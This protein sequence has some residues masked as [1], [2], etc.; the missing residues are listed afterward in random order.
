V[1]FLMSMGVC[2]RG[3][4]VYTPRKPCQVLLQNGFLGYK[5]SSLPISIRIEMAPSIS[6]TFFIGKMEIEGGL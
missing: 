2:R 3:E 6:H 5:L 1:E 4:N